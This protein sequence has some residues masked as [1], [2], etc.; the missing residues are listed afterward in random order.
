MNIFQQMAQT[1]VPRFEAPRGRQTYPVMKPIFEA[2]GRPLR[3]N[4]LRMFGGDFEL[5][6]GDDLVGTL[7]FRSAFGSMA[8][9]TSADGTW[10]FKRTGIWRPEI[11]VPLSGNDADVAVFR[12]NTWKD[13]GWLEF[14]DGR[15]FRA[16][17]NCWM[18]RFEIRSD[19]DEVLMS[20]RASSWT[21]SS[22]EVEP[23]PEARRLPELSLLLLFGWYLAVLTRSDAAAASTG[24][25]C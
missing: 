12:N 5:R 4:R 18:T 21:D 20:L 8:T 23:G 17:N 16:T 7:S 24:G 9:A 11:T 1:I 19:R 22:A 2:T 3:W 15:R 25:A 14:R 6:A 13:G 10:T